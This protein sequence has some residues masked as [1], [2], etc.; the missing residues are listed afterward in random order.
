MKPLPRF[1]VWDFTAKKMLFFEGIFNRRPKGHRLS[2][3][4]HCS[5]I[6]D[7]Y[8]KY[9]YEQDLIVL[10]GKFMRWVVR[11]D[12]G[13]FQALSRE[14]DDMGFSVSA[15]LRSYETRRIIGNYYESPKIVTK[16]WEQSKAGDEAAKQWEE[17][18]A[19]REGA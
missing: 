5:N 13:E 17:Q 11:Y 19:Q 8:G 18:E 15:W 7:R 1:R 10:K 14:N 12:S 4:M 9:I 2:D 16:W 6:K 3:V